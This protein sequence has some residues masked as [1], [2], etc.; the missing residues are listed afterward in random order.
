MNAIGRIPPTRGLVGSGSAPRRSAADSWSSIW[1]ISPSRT[2]SSWRPSSA[3]LGPGRQ[4]RAGRCRLHGGGAGMNAIGRIPPTRGLGAG[5]RRTAGPRSGRS[6]RRGP[7]AAGAPPR[8]SGCH[9]GGIR[10]RLQ[11]RIGTLRRAERDQAHAADTLAASSA[12]DGRRRRMGS[13]PVMPILPTPCRPRTGRASSRPRVPRPPSRPPR[14]GGLPRG[15]RRPGHDGLH[16]VGWRDGAPRALALMAARMG[17]APVMPILP[18]PCRP[19]TG[20]ASSRP[21]V[22]SDGLHYV[23]W[24]DGAPRALALVARRGGCVR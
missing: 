24:R 16:Y 3:G 14:R 23:G 19:R 17:S 2:A 12:K 21:R 15:R 10:P 18:T 5:R 9:R 4:G 1:A 20:R 6:R 22:P 11:E 7:P 13:A 8:R